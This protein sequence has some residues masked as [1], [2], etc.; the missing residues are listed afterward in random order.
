MR[1]LKRNYFFSFSGYIIPLSYGFSIFVFQQFL[2][3]WVCKIFLSRISKSAILSS[4][5]TI[6]KVV[7][8]KLQKLYL[9]CLDFY[10]LSFGFSVIWI[11]SRV[12]G[13]YL[14]AFFSFF[15]SFD[16]SG[17]YRGK[18]D[19]KL[20]HSISQELC[21]ICFWF[22]VHMCKMMKSP[23]IFFSFFQNFQVFQSSLINTKRKFW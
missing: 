9:Y 5:L 4:K 21:F 14:Q 10:V 15:R 23:P 2:F 22:L 8:E 16:F 3:Y 11:N 12:R 20:S 19:K 6:S 13:W 7:Y 18:S 17:Y 1:P